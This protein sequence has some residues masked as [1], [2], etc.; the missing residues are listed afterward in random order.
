M[1]KAI[2]KISK[3]TMIYITVMSKK[4]CNNPW[5]IFLHY[6]KSGKIEFGDLLEY[7]TTTGVNG[8]IYRTAH[9]L[10]K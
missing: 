9:T 3:D 1:L 7:P 6:I 5:Y 4:E 8:G 10:I 2:T